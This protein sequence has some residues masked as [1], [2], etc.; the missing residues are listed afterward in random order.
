MK[1]DGGMDDLQ[2][3]VLFDSISVI[4]GRWQV[5]NERL[6]ATELCLQLRR[7]HLE[8]GLNSVH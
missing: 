2:F 3:Y 6:C 5:D 7:F 8:R 1:Q 4:S